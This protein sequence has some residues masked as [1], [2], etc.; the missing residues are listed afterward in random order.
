MDI[1]KQIEDRYTDRAR[2]RYGYH[3]SERIVTFEAGTDD[4]QQAVMFKMREELIP[5]N[6]WTYGPEKLRENVWRI[7][8]GYDSGD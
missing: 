3:D 4:E 7:N 8:Y 1:V 6:M 2:P 5:G